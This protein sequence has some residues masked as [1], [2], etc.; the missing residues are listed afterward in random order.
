MGVWVGVWVYEGVGLWVC[1]FFWCVGVWVCGCVEVCVF[2]WVF[3]GVWVCGRMGGLVCGCVGV[4]LP[5][6]P[7]FLGG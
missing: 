5:R 6:P 3:L 1:G 4:R 2:V 7:L